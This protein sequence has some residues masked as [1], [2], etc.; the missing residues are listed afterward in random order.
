MSIET[1]PEQQ[2][3]GAQPG[4]PSH[5]KEMTL[6]EHLGELR[7]RLMVTGIAIV[8]GLVLAAV[9]IP[10]YNSVTWAV[11]GLVLTPAQ[12][13]VQAIRPGETLFTYFQVALLCGAAFAM[14]VI[15]YQI[16]AFI[17]PALLP[18]EQ[19]LLFLAVPGVTIFFVLGVAFSYFVLVPFAIR[20]L[21]A[22]GSEMV[23]PNWAFSEY[24]GTITM[25]LFWMG[26]TFELP[27]VMLTLAKLGIVDARRLAGM[28]RWAIVLAFVAAAVITPTPD[29]FNQTMI[30]LPIYLLFEI[31]ILLARLARPTKKA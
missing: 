27:L 18:N 7:H 19:R 17:L 2:T 29:P 25:L 4:P 13:A 30:A 14:P 10:G 15:I 1:L 16:L 28:R 8:L 12:G 5:D 6:L 20:F 11:I 26:V 9:P 24:V 31:G 22:F 23:P 3:N 21:L